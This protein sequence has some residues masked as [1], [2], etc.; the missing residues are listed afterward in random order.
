MS[1]REGDGLLETKSI[2]MSSDRRTRSVS[3]GG[4]YGSVEALRNSPLIHQNLV[5]REY[6]CFVAHACA[7]QQFYVYSQL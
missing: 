3:V 5:N 6:V 1:S 2:E 7:L 4:L